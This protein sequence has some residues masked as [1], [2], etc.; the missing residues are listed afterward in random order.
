MKRLRCVLL[1]AMM[2]LATMQALAKSIVFTLSDGTLVYYQLSSTNPPKMVVEDGTIWVNAD[3]YAFADVLN[4]YVS[5]QDAPVAIDN[6]QVKPQVKMDGS[7]LYVSANDKAVKVYGVNGVEVDAQ[8]SVVDGM[9]TVGI[10]QL[11][12]GVYIVK[13]GDA[14][15]KFNKK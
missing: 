15:F 11:P 13:V 4:F 6:V 8:V 1:I 3:K 12:H 7:H 5:A 10:G 2:S 9:A 14:S